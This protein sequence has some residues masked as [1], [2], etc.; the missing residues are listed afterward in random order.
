[1]DQIVGILCDT[2]FNLCY[3]WCNKSIYFK[4]DR[5]LGRIEIFPLLFYVSI[6]N[7]HFLLNSV[8]LAPFSEAF[9]FPY[10]M[11]GITIVKVCRCTNFYAKSIES[12]NGCVFLCVIYIGYCHLSILLLLLKPYNHAYCQWFKKY[13][14]GP[15]VSIEVINVMVLGDL[16]G[17]RL[18]YGP[19]WCTHGG[20]SNELG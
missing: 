3:M 14:V 4:I 2:K 8:C 9:Y 15:Y 20:S 11:I 1:M 13:L 7:M 10:Y 12:W 6:T 17:H 19:F 16:W 18:S 5:N